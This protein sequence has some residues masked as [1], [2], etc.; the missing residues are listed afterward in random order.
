M[1]KVLLV[2]IGVSMLASC[3]Q[4]SSEYKRVNAVNDSLRLENDRNASEMNEMLSTL[5]DIEADIQSIRDAENYLNIQQQG[6][7][8][9][10]PS[11]REHIKDNMQLI[12]ETLKKNREQLSQLE[13]RLKNSNVRLEALEKTLSRLTSELDQK[14]TMIIALQEDLAKKNIHIEELDRQLATLNE[15][16]EGLSLTASAQ[17]ETM[18]TQD[19]ALNTAYY[20]FGTSKELKNQKILTG[21]GLFSKSKALQGDFNRDYF[22]SVDIREVTEIPLFASKAG[23]KSNHPAGSY[24]FL[25]DEDKNLTFKIIDVKAFWSLGKYLVIEVG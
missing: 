11:V 17:A 8:E 13:G 2:C 24:E 4:N 1:K 22:I 9:L 7:V 18:K 16:L 19:K 3:V 23:L 6:N 12:A 21:G 20:C 25:K 5:N 10:T 14:A 15:D